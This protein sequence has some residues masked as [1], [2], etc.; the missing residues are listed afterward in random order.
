MIW[1]WSSKLSYIF[2]NTP[3]SSIIRITN[4]DIYLKLTKVYIIKADKQSMY[5]QWNFNWSNKNISM[6]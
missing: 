6:D 3:L 2:N 4:Y 1:L 5:Y